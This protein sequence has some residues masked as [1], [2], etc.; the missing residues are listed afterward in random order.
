MSVLQEI[1]K[2]SKGRPSWQQDA[3]RRLVLNDEL[4]D[5]DVQELVLICKG[6]HG[7]EPS[8]TIFPLAKEHIPESAAGSAPVSLI[9]IVHGHGV[10]ALADDQTLNFGS[11][12][13]LVY[14]DNGA[15]KTGYIRILKNACRARGVEKILGNVG[16][17]QA[18]V[19]AMSI[20]YREGADGVCRQWP[21]DDGDSLLSQVS[22]FD[23]KSAA[24]YLNEKTDV[25]FRPVGLDIFDKL[26]RACKSVRSQL[27]QEQRGLR[28]DA[29]QSFQATMQPDTEVGRFLRGITLMTTS[30]E[31]SRLA[32]FTDEEAQ[33][34]SLIE[35]SLLDQKAND[36]A[37]LI[38]QLLLRSQRARALSEHLYR[39]EQALSDI[40]VATL[41][42][43]RADGM[44]VA[45]LAKQISEAA[46]QESSLPGT[47]SDLWRTLWEAA[48]AFSSADAYP[49]QTFPVVG[50]GAKCVLCQQTLEDHSSTRLTQFEAFVAS[51]LERELGQLRSS[52]AQHKASLTE[53]VVVPESIAQTLE[54]LSIDHV[55][56]T[57]SLRAAL[58]SNE[59]RRAAVL[60]ALAHRQDLSATCPTV[61][62]ASASVMDLVRQF[63]ERIAALRQNNHAD[64]VKNLE[65]KAQE[66]RARR[67]LGAQEKIVL[68]ELS[69]RR[70]YAA[71]SQC[72][73]ETQTQ[74]IT[75]KNT[76]LTKEAVS[77]K[78]RRAFHEELAKFSFHHLEIELREQGGDQGV[79]YHKLSFK[80]ARSVALPTVIS[81]GEQRC[82]SIA[83]F[84]AELSTENGQ[85]AIVF[86][87]PISSLDHRWRQTVAKRLVEAARTR[88]VIVFTHD[89][90]FLLQLREF[91]EKA[92]IVPLDQ[93]IQHI[94]NK[95]AGIST[96]ELPWVAR[97]VKQRIG[98]LNNLWQ[99]ADKC[100]R[101]GHPERY[102]SD[103]ASIYGLLREAWERAV[104]EVMF[105]GAIVRYRA[106][107]QTQKIKAVVDIG[108]ADYRALE[109]G[110]A[111][112]ST[113][114]AGHDQA[115]AANVPFP[116]PNEIKADIKLLDDWVASIVSRRK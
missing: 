91:A 57:E 107:I 21:E 108:E 31:V 105:N 101:D 115:A 111:K 90:V 53:L 65:L 73:E 62:S 56:L 67:L 79:F 58:A 14:G 97:N 26:V 78:L 44:R 39:I 10:N 5:K 60:D 41:F 71:Y 32:K 25:A 4:T 35:Q 38:Q 49:K 75:L 113:W 83:A 84:F 61:I 46:F 92:E 22:I 66:M 64:G 106:S 42:K 116:E 72:I 94:S 80:N 109:A 50:R 81:E 55:E 19:M 9:S 24:V 18:G 69:R 51:T 95:G 3:L 82:L 36:P 104:E 112:C 89:I 45:L 93:H 63:D 99:A 6:G 30:E 2:W 47:G 28:A 86:D 34:F 33:Q 16:V 110:M 59:A 1:L 100:F 74:S 13:T 88:Q 102:Q 27:E 70:H 77:Y 76:A 15:G 48:R 12:L 29:F 11:G 8:Q 96:E 54:E 52:Y 40:A 23:T 20:K 87:D 114:L 68:G 43:C 37:K 7:L 98:R 103:A 85:S 17:N